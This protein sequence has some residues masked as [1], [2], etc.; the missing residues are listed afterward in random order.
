MATVNAMMIG[1]ILAWGP[2]LLVFIYI[3]RDLRSAP[4]DPDQR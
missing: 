3:L 4:R 2:L 1:A